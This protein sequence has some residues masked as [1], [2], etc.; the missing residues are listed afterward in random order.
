MAVKFCGSGNC[1]V[2][3]L[4]WKD[5]E[6]QLSSDQVYLMFSHCQKVDDM[7]YQLPAIPYLP[8]DKQKIEK[9]SHNPSTYYHGFFFLNRMFVGNVSGKEKVRLG[10]IIQ[11]E[12]DSKNVNLFIYKKADSNFAF[13]TPFKLEISR[14]Q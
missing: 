5:T 13:T 6:P 3:C 10:I 8:Q 4:L 7:C 1:F 2:P 12:R 9:V 11:T 14:L